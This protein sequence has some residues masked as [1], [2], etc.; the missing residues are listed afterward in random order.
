MPFMGTCPVCNTD[1]ILMGGGTI[2]NL[3][4]QLGQVT[5]SPGMKDSILRVLNRNFC[6][7]CGGRLENIRSTHGIGDKKGGEPKSGD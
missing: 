7:T 2:Y 1:T 3:R 4:I 6:K 5:G